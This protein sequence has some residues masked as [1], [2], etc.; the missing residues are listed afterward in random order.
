MYHTFPRFFFFIASGTTDD[1]KNPEDLFDHWVK[2][3]ADLEKQAVES[4]DKLPLK[5]SAYEE[6]HQ[7]NCCSILQLVIRRSLVQQYRDWSS[8]VVD[9][10]LVFFAGLMLGIRFF[11]NLFIQ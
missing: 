9:N 10:G 7:A 11:L 3:Q 4:D 8:F 5:S 2:Y 6:R 1:K